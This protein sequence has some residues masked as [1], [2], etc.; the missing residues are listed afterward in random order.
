MRARDP[1][2]TGPESRFG[3]TEQLEPEA[4]ENEPVEVAPRGSNP[5]LTCW[6]AVT[7]TVAKFTAPSDSEGLFGR[8]IGGDLERDSEPVS[9]FRHD[10]AFRRWRAR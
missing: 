9:G 3:A 4:T 5:L 6:S 10:L 1:A 8:P 7:A 2:T